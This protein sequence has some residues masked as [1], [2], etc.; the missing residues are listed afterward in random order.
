MKTR[1]LP[2]P[3]EV[4]LPSLDDGYEAGERE[5]AGRG[6][7]VSAQTQRVAHHRAHGEPAEHRP[8]RRDSGALPDLVVEVGQLPV[9][10][11]EGLRIRVADA[12]DDVPVVAGP[13]R[14]RERSARG[15]CVQA[16][17]R[18][19][20]VRERQKIPLVRTTAVVQDEQA[21]RRAVRGALEKRE[22]RH[23]APAVSLRAGSGAPSSLR[24]R[25]TGDRSSGTSGCSGRATA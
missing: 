13:A 21:F 7:P 8:L 20:H 16:A 9:R 10:G 18:V 15:D 12:R 17:L 1:V 6:R 25:R 4:R 14:Q 23:A 11:V 19:E 2:G 22:V 24:T 3:P 5:D